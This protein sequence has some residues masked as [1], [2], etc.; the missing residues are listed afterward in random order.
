MND[1][2]N[3]TR[4]CVA[5]F[6][7]STA[8]QGRSGLGIEAQRAA[9]LA[10]LGQEWRLIEEVV[11]VASGRSPARPG[12]ERAVAI[13]RAQNAVLVIARLCRLSRDPHLLFAL[14][15]SGVEF[16]AVDMPGASQF[17]VGVMALVAQEEA[18]LSADRTRQALAARR[19]RGLPLGGNNPMIGHH[20]LDGAAASAAVRSAKARQRA[21]ALKPV[22][23]ALRADGANSLAEIA[24]GLN[25]RGLSAPRGGDWRAAS[26]RDLLRHYAEVS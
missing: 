13:C 23:D 10:H 11:E 20:A 21:T 1:K 19:A 2:A 24:D 22:I 12:L 4:R 26:V 6:R 16:L 14:Q 7:V 25:D 17:A 18:R 9:V 15:R 3:P 8:Q 5:L